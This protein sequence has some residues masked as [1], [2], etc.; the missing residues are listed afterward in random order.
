ME[1]VFWDYL[2]QGAQSSINKKR[3]F[4][5]FFMKGDVYFSIAACTNAVKSGWGRNGRD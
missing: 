5:V 4:G 2:L 3:P 1:Q